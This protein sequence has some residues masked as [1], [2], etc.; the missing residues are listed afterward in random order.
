MQ[1]TLIW[2][3][4][5]VIISIVFMF[6]FRKNLAGF[7][8]K[9]ISIGKNG[10]VTVNPQLQTT[11]ETK[12]STEELLKAFSSNVILHQEETI[13]RLV[14]EKGITDAQDTIVFLLR[15]LASTQ[16]A[17]W[18]EYVNS[19][20]WGSQIAILQDLNAKP[21]GETP[22]VLMGFYNIAAQTWPDVFVNYSFAQY[23]GFLITHNLL[24][25]DD[26]KYYITDVGKEFLQYLINSGKPMFR[27]F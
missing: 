15:L 4:A 7:I 20:I 10:I 17:F 5:V 8:D 16:V 25:W 19:I 22:L 14:E 18:F 11:P 26:N 3:G 21:L 6:V 1:T 27:P 24:K 9:I 2:A 13:R 23:I 12:S